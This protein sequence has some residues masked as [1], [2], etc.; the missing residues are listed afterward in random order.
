MTTCLKTYYDIDNSQMDWSVYHYCGIFALVDDLLRVNSSNRLE[1]AEFILKNIRRFKLS[2]N[3]PISNEKFIETIVNRARE[4]AFSD[5]L[6]GYL[7]QETAL[8]LC[9]AGENDFDQKWY[10]F[11]YYYF[12]DKVDSLKKTTLN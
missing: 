7:L 6:S 9:Q 4:V 3:A 11:A 5:S 2:V 8:V 12:T 1:R 10:R